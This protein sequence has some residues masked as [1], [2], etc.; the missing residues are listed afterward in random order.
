MVEVPDEIRARF[1]ELQ[2]DYLATLG[3]KL[4]ELET[5]AQ[6]LTPQAAEGETRTALDSV[7]R[8]SHKLS[9][10][11]GTFGFPSLSR[12]ADNLE[13]Q[14][15]ELVQITGELSPGQC[16]E[17]ER[18]VMTVLSVCADETQVRRRIVPV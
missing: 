9:G 12:A 14:C 18:L 13:Q 11:A 17:I 4:A 5:A 16:A 2:A 1:E 10:S 15:R 7:I 8:L 3:V 6:S